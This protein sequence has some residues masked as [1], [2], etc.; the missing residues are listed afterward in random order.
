MEF[1]G[2][3]KDRKIF[4]FGLWISD[5]EHERPFICTTYGNKVFEDNCSCYLPK[6][7]LAH[8]HN[9]KELPECHECYLKRW[10]GFEDMGK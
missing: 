2:K 7:G 6:V 3:G 10:D 9:H 1:K 8:R 4:I 5:I